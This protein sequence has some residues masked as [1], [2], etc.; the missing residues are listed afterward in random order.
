MDKVVQDRG[1]PRLRPLIVLQDLFQAM[2]SKGA[3]NHTKKQE[4]RA[5]SDGSN[6]NQNPEE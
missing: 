2:G 6:A 4:A 5:N 1:F 3:Q